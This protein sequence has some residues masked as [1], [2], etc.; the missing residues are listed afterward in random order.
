MTAPRDDALADIDATIADWRASGLRARDIAG[1]IDCCSRWPWI[2]QRMIAMTLP[3]SRQKPATATLIALIGMR[4]YRGLSQADIGRRL[5]VSWQMISQYE[6][7][8]KPPSDEAL[9][10]WRKMLG[11]RAQAARPAA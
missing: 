11:L 10:A 4:K 2:R 7:G 9:A 6:K 3:R 1:Q 8:Y 5:G